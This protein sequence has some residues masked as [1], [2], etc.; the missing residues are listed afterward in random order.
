MISFVIKTLYQSA[1]GLSN[2]LRRI[3]GLLIQADNF[4]LQ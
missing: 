2:N 3:I 1:K 4:L